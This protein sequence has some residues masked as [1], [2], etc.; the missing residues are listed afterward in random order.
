M[1]FMRILLDA[2]DL[3]DVLEHSK[4]VTI[5]EFDAWLRR[6][7][8]S[9]V[10]SLCNIRGLAGPI[11][12]NESH[13][14]RIREYVDRLEHLPHC[15]IR[16]DIDLMELRSALRSFEAGR[17]YEAIDPYVPRFDQ[18][19][20]P[21]ANS[22]KVVYPLWEIVHD[23]WKACPQIFR[24]QTKAHKLHKVAMSMDRDK[25]QARSPQ[26]AEPPSEPIREYLM[27]K[28][29]VT[30]ER[31]AEVA[32]WVAVSPFRC[33]GL[34]LVRTVGSAM[35]QNR[36]YLAR[37]DDIFDMAEIMAF[38]Y[39]DAA[40]V[41]RTMLDYFSRAIRSLSR[42]GSPAKQTPRVFRKLQDL[43]ESSS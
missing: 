41:D 25:P 1:T 15:Y 6:R 7:S 16:T 24:P 26:P 20:P 43:M 5:S 9:V 27:L 14:P 23:L 13:I 10:Y 39:V 17:E 2:K 31:A 30:P 36:N 34:W 18:V 19:F 33:P 3:I 12:F 28:M 4:P 37:K 21:F 32:S 40:T 8:G 29:S 35:S 38:P 22:D 11:G 42:T